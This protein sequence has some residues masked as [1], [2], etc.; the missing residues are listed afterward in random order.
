MT[1]LADLA[2]LVDGK[3]IGNTT[4]EGITS[5]S[6][7]VKSGVLFAAVPGQHVHGARFAGGAISAG[8]SAVVT[9]PEGRR[10]SKG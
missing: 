10:S 1:Q 7:A 3:H 2:A 8:A 5:D 9:D 4:V 6:R